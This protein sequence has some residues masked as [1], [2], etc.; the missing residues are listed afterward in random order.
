LYGVG[1]KKSALPWYIFDGSGRLERI[2]FAFDLF[3][4]S[5]AARYHL[6]MESEKKSEVKFGEGEQELMTA[7]F[8]RNKGRMDFIYQVG[9][10][11][12]FGNRNLPILL[13][14]QVTESSE[15]KG[16]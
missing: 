5:K 9:G 7:W 14:E 13:L 16:K 2:G 12:R 6:T 15:G 3:E 10:K 4:N 11:Q 8:Q 1:K